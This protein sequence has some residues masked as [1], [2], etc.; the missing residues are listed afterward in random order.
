M[1]QAPA[2]PALPPFSL[3]GWPTERLA[4]PY[5]VYR[6]YREE[7][8]V[9]RAAPAPGPP[10]APATFYVLGHDEVAAVLSDAAYGRSARRA[11]TASTRA[12]E[13]VPE[14]RPTLRAMVQNWLVFL[15]PPR[16]TELRSVLNREFSPGVVTRLRGR[17]RTI[18]ADLLA[19]LGREVR[20]DGS[21]D[22]VR[23]FA[24][25][26]PILVISELLGVPPEDWPWLRDQAVAVQQASSSRVGQCPAAHQ[27]A[28]RAARHLTDYFLDLAARRR[29]APGPDLVSL[30]VSAQTRGAP[31]NDTE[32]VA[33]CV[34]LMTAGHET[35]TNTLAKAV[36]TLG[37]R[38]AAWAAL[39]ER[40]LV[41]LPAVDELVRFD[42]PVQTVTRWAYREVTLGGLDVP[43]GSRLVAV[44]GAA[45]R[46]PARFPEPDALLLDRRGRNL[47]FGLGIHYCLGANLARTEIEIGLGLLLSA[48]DDLGGLRGPDGSGALTVTDVAYPDDLVFHGPSRLRLHLG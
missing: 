21:T 25:P 48:L 22:L 41:P 14:D 28:D 35:T 36:L 19:D 31:L 33:T 7:A 2:R 9:H 10:D 40:P 37:A 39:R 1:T 6:R 30:L 44:L 45:N 20:R 32:T 24:A 3:T 26:F 15:D 17:I 43:R 29:A 5:P 34:H 46:D 8:P 42:P 23:S 11:A 47:G 13:L 16:H 27:I 18:A 12:P 38:P 4:D